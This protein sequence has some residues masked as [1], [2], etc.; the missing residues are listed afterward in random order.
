MRSPHSGFPAGVLGW[1]CLCRADGV[2]VCAGIDFRQSR[3]WHISFC[4]STIVCRDFSWWRLVS[5]ACTSVFWCGRCGYS[6]VGLGALGV[7]LGGGGGVILC[8][9]LFS[10]YLVRIQSRMFCLKGKSILKKIFEP[11]GGEKK[12]FRPS[13]GIRGMLPRKIFQNIV[14]R[15]G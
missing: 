2:F 14:L 9:F 13:W 15:I 6:G 7:I 3:F 1:G 4:C 10:L 8:V 5:Q 11:R 12:F